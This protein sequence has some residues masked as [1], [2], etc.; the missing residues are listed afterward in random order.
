MVI[1]TNMVQ[2]YRKSALAAGRCGIQG[3]LFEEVGQ[4]MLKNNPVQ[5]AKGDK[6]CRAKVAEGEQPWVSGECFK[7][8]DPSWVRR[9]G[10]KA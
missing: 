7:G 4:G 8:L 2:F 1:W 6:R 3:R 5:L 9:M 10:L